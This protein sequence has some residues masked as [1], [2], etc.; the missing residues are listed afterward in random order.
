MADDQTSPQEGVPYKFECHKSLQHRNIV[1]DGAW[2]GLNG[3]G[4]IILN[5]W[6]D[7]PPLPKTIIAESAKDGSYFTSKLPQIINSTEAGAVR[8][9]E[10]SVYLSLQAARHISA[11]LQNFIQLAEDTEKKQS[12]RIK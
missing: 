2:L 1:A 11:T 6:T 12:E 5:F 3:H 7:S 4:K 9:Y 10:V 8:E